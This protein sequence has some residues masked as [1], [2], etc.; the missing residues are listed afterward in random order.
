MGQSSSSP[1]ADASAASKE[2][3]SGVSLSPE[4]EGMRFVFL[5]LV[6]SNVV[7]TLKLTCKLFLLH[8]AA[9]LQDFQNEILQQEW[10][11]YRSTVLERHRQRTFDRNQAVLDLQQHSEQR[12]KLLARTNELDAEIES[13]QAKFTDLSTAVEY[14]V[15]KLG[16][17]Y[18]VSFSEPNS[19]IRPANGITL[20]TKRSTTSTR[21]CLGPRAHVIDCMSKYRNDVRPCSAYVDALEMC[22]S[23]IVTHPRSRIRQA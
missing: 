3:T 13:L 10:T 8:T 22:V 5:Q 21:T 9:M 6:K 1:T 18:R 17:K 2:M 23:D 4:L 7:A 20:L 14:D 16:E 11:N 15:Q 19:G 12:K